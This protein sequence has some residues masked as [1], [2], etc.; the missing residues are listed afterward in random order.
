[1]AK[2]DDFLLR[3]RHESPLCISYLPFVDVGT[4]G[5]VCSGGITGCVVGITEIEILVIGNR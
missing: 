4:G 3:Y 2:I 5:V 1:M